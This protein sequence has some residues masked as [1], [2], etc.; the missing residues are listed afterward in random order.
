MDSKL[1]YQ[2]QLAVCQYTVW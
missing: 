2:H 1:L